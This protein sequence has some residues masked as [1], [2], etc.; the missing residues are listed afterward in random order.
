MDSFKA[1]VQEARDIANGR[2]AEASRALAEREKLTKRL[3]EIE[4]IMAAAKPLPERLARLTDI[5]N[6]RSQ[7]LCPSCFLEG[8]GSNVMDSVQAD[9]APAFDA[10]RC[11]VCDHFT[12]V[13]SKGWNDFGGGWRPGQ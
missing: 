6:S 8:R 10:F 3:A 13:P 1:L 5:Y 2:Q 7:R 12:L 4:N 11:P 9:D